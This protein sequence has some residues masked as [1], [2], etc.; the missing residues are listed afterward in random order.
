VSQPPVETTY[1]TSFDDFD[2]VPVLHVGQ[3]VRHPKFGEGTVQY[4]EGEKEKQRIIAYFPSVG[5][6]TLS[7]PFARLEIIQ[8]P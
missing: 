5:I 3:R 7:I 2:E 4:C 1:D 8:E 6:K